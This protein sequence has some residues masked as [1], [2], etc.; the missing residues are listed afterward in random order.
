MNRNGRATEQTPL[1]ASPVAAARRNGDSSAAINLHARMLSP[2]ASSVLSGYAS[3]PRFA[4]PRRVVRTMDSNHS[5]NTNTPTAR[6]GNLQALLR[7]A[8]N[9]DGVFRLEDD[10]DEDEEQN[11]GHTQNDDDDIGDAHDGHDGPG[12]YFAS[13]AKIICT[14]CVK[15][16]FMQVKRMLEL[17]VKKADAQARATVS[18]ASD[19]TRDRKKR[20]L[21]QDAVLA[22]FTTHDPRHHMNVLHLAV[23]YDHPLIVELLV[24]TA[25]KYC[26]ARLPEILE[27]TCAT[28]KHCATPL[29]LAA[30]VASAGVLIDHGASLNA[31]NSSGM[32]A[33]H[34]A[35]STGNAG[36]VSLLIS[37]GADV[38]EMDARGATALHWAVFEG[39]QYTAMLLVGH[40]ANQAICDSEKH[41]ALMIACA[42]GDAFLAKQLVVEG[43]PLEVKDKQGR[44]AVDIARQGG[45]FETVSALKAGASDRFVN[46]LSQ[47][48]GAVV[49]FWTMVL[50]AETLSLWY[51]VPSA[52]AQAWWTGESASILTCVVVCAM[53]TYVWLKD[54]GYVPKSTQPA[55]ELLALECTS[56]PCPT[57]VTL[58]PLRSKHC[59]ACRRCVFRFDHHCPWINN[60]IGLGNHRAFLVFLASLVLYCAILGNLSSAIL[61]GYLPLYPVGFGFATT[62]SPLLLKLVHCLLLF[63][64]LLFGAPTL[65]LLVLQLRNV[66][67]NLTTN[68]MFNKDKYPYLR[69]PM[70]EFH[71]PYDRGCWGNFAEVCAK[72]NTEAN[73]VLVDP[74]AEPARRRSTLLVD[75][76]EN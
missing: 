33:L 27:T 64:S 69:T 16:D 43:A 63:G 59:S 57:C 65:G 40:G 6:R 55:H 26:T 24:A 29:M 54:P 2:A 66:A 18:D 15:G 23:L 75:P 5:T 68:E 73:A 52:E 70:D 74:R 3:S 20:T 45:H 60:C 30:S 17:V 4:S 50:G 67:S 61:L 37:R 32:T 35:A 19:V 28:P 9:T 39:F 1:I 48:G 49:F 47:R 14:A 71:N 38:N 8:T 53:Y 25:T 44:I 41:T 56:V 11:D 12:S 46:A 62:L 22:L 36:V 51:A 76:T 21:L 72:H 10:D 7:D 34:Y 13:P 58:K 42:L 31:K